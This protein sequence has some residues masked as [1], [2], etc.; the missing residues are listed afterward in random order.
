MTKD[1]EEKNLK[2]EN[3][4]EDEIIDIGYDID[5]MIYMNCL[6]DIGTCQNSECN[7]KYEKE[8]KRIRGD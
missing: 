2:E 1:F 6:Y 3:L 8:I 7:D 5:N 4:T